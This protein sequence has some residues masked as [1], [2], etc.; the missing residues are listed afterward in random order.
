METLIDTDKIVFL[1][2]DGVINIDSPDY[3]KTP[4]EF[5]FIP[6]SRE[7]IAELKKAE[8][9]AAKAEADAE[10]NEESAEQPAKKKEKAQPSAEESASE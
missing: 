1:D 3:I 10:E 4:E 8:A 6:G 7:A 9:A 5:H 2:R